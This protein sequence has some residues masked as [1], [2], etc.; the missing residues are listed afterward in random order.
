VTGSQVAEALSASF[1]GVIDP[2]AQME[3]LGTGFA[4]VEG[5]VWNPAES[6]LYFSDIPAS[7]RRR[8]SAE[9]GI[10]I[11]S[12]AT[13]HGNGMTYDAD[14][15]LIVCEHATSRLVALECDKAQI[16]VAHW[17]GKELNSPND[18]CVRSDGAIFFTD[19][20]I[21]RTTAGVGGV[22]EPQL[23]FEGVFM[24]RPSTDQLTR[25]A[26]DFEVPNGLC[27]S[28]DESVLYVNESTRGRIRAFEIDV[29]AD[30]SRSWLFAEGIGTADVAV[31]VVDGMKCDAEGNVW[32]TGPRGIWVFAPSGEQIGMI[33][34]PEVAANFHWGGPAWSDLYICAS[35]SLYRLA[36]NVT[37]RQEPFMTRSGVDGV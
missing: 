29:D 4:F 2:G 7:V 11:V 15:R 1:D 16:L 34:T 9:A 3:Q 26:A 19:P 6:C 32:V 33:Y 21:G 23:D 17:E 27:F 37:G 36:T 12:T 22:R 10:E 14:L 18:V 25:V 30:I 8:W 5:P 24:L 28:P 35:S 13:N 20:S 31:G